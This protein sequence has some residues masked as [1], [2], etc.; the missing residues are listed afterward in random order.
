MIF[1]ELRIAV[2]TGL[3]V[4]FSGQTELTGKSD[5]TGMTLKEIILVA[6]GVAAPTG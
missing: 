2:G 6:R 5:Q 4:G 1:A 3:V